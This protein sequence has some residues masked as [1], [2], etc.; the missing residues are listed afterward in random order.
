MYGPLTGLSLL[1][2]PGRWIE[3]NEEGNSWELGQGLEP[4]IQVSTKPQ[5]DK[6]GSLQVLH[7]WEQ[8]GDPQLLRETASKERAL[9]RRESFW[10]PD[11]AGFGST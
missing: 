4:L 6:M 9:Y 7:Y 5:R 10:V 1:P 3:E 8:P 11:H 2:T